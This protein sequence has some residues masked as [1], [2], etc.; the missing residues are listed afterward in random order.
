MGRRRIKRCIT[1]EL[2]DLLLDSGGRWFRPVNS[3]DEVFPGVL[4]G[5]ADTA[6]STQSVKE[7]SITHILNAAQGHNNHAY[8]GYVSTSPTYYAKLRGIKYLGIPAMDMP[9]FYIK[10][11][12]RDAAD[13]I[14]GALKEG[15]RVLVHCQCGISRSA[16]L[17]AGFLMLKRGMNVQSALATIKKKRNIF[18]NQGFL[19][20]LCDLDYE[21][22]R[23]GDLPDNPEDRPA[24]PV[25][26]TDREVSPFRNPNA[27]PRFTLVPSRVLD[28]YTSTKNY[29]VPRRSTSVDR[30]EPPLKNF[31]H[32]PLID[33]SL[34][35]ARSPARSLSPARR[36]SLSYSPYDDEVEDE[37]SHN[38]KV[39]D[40]YRRY[41]RSVTSPL[42]SVTAKTIDYDT[43]RYPRSYYYDRYYP[44]Y[45]YLSSLD[46]YYDTFK[47]HRDVTPLL[48]PSTVY[49]TYKVY[50]EKAYLM[51]SS[52]VPTYPYTSRYYP[53]VTRYP[54]S[55]RTLLWT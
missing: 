2:K 55:T 29:V 41:A 15:G 1:A 8:G 24:S 42:P 18:P 16:A 53:M 19:S 7:L 54:L 47:Y 37:L 40:T 11:Y 49:R 44:T 6:L 27:Y 31:Q 13:F 39:F 22:R 28:T 9:G 34:R 43:I 50:P 32:N 23:S 4:L 3:C 10:P 33:S 46:K 48:S 36:S 12:L 26:E 14:N 5:D 45:D 51:G 52:Y 25:L 38:P 17:V 35:R 20:Q 21:L 30:Y